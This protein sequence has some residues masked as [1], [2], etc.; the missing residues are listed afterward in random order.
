M[1]QSSFDASAGAEALFS[2]APAPMLVVAPDAPRFTILEANQAYC[3]V[4][5]RTRD[6]LVGRALFEAFPDNP[7]DPG[8]SGTANLQASMERAIATR[9][10]DAMPVQRYD[11]VGPDGQYEERCWEPVNAPVLEKGE[12]VAVIHHAFDATARLRAEA[13]VREA[14]DRRQFLLDI[15]DAT[16]VLTDPDAVIAATTRRLGERLGAARVAFADI[17][18]AADRAIIHGQWTSA[19]VPGLPETVRVSDFGVMIG[20]L[21]QRRT[22]RIDDICEHAATQDSIALLGAISA[23]AIVSV[24][25]HKEGRFLANLN[26]HHAAPRAWTDA[27][28]ALI[29]EVAER[30]WE[31]VERVRA[32]R[33]L[34][35]SEARY[36]QIVEGAEDFAIVQLDER[37]VVT[38]WNTGA[39]RILGYAREEAVGQPGA[40]FFTPEDRAAGAPD[41]EIERAAVEERAVNERWHVRKDG[42]RFW[43]SG[44]IMRSEGEQRGYLKV[45]RDRTAEHEAETQLRESETRFRNMADHAPVMMWVTDAA[46]FCTYLNKAWYDF[47]GQTVEQA[48]GF[49]WLNATHAEDKPEAERVF[50]ESNA[51]HAPFRA[52]YRLRRADGAYRWAIDAASPRFGPSGEYLG[53]VGS[54][55]DIDERRESERALQVNEERLRLA[56]EAAELG[57]WDVD[58]VEDLLIWPPRVKEMF[59][60]SEDRPVTMDD[61]YGGLHP[62]DRAATVEAFALACDPVARALYDVEYRT[63]G[64]E[65]QVVR[66]VSAKGRA[67]FDEAGRCLRVVGTAI[68]ITRRKVA[69]T[70]LRRSE[71]R[72]RLL[73]ELD[74]ALRT[75]RDAE[76]AMAY[77]A[78]LL[79]RHLGVARTAYAD[80]DADNDRFIIRDDYTAPG[81]ATSV[82]TYSLDLFGPRAS[83]DMRQ[84]RTL[85]VRNVGEEL[86]PGEGREMFQAIGIDAIIC[87]PLVKDGR[88]RAMMAVHNAA[89]RDWRADE[90]SLVETV[91]ER[92]WAHV[93][94]VAAE[95]RLRESEERYRTLFTSIESGFCVVEVAYEESGRTDY[96]VI[97]ANPAFFRQTGF[98]ETIVGQWLREAAPELEEAW[99]KTYGRIARTGA[100]ERFEQGS[101][102]LGRW[103][104]VYAFPIGEPEEQRLAI[105]FS[106]ISARRQ[107]EEDLRELNDTL[108]ARVEARTAELQAAHEQ[109]RQSQKMEAMGQLTGG[110]AHDF[111]NLL[112]PIVGSLDLLQRRGVGDERERRLI[113]GAVQS[114]DRAKTLVQ[115]LLSFARRQPLQTMAVDLTTLV[116]GMAE[117]IAS[118]TGPQIRVSVEAADN[119]PPAKAD[120]NQLEMALLNL[121]V[122]ARDAMPE[123]GTLRISVNEEAVAPGHSSKLPAGR[124]VRLSVADTGIGMNEETL[125]RSVEPFF[126]TKG[127]GKGTGLG[128]SSVHGL[129]SQ[130]GG[131]LT[132][133]S[134]QGVGTNV[135]LWLPI[136]HSSADETRIVPESS[137]LAATGTA[138]L[139]DDEELVRMSTADMLSELGYRVVEAAS[140]E[141]ALDKLREGL[142]PDLLVSDHLMPGMNG[143]DLARIV[144]AE[145]PGVQ[146]LIV[147]GYAEDDGVAPDLPRLTKPFR[148]DDLVARLANLQA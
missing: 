60:I 82:G 24:P 5:M 25:L 70:A 3:A 110:V 9:Q 64:K 28:V 67:L 31:W 43:G 72:L 142:H 128:L 113:G 143:T 141:E 36:R 81:I 23:R 98:S 105:L 91:V 103:F 19:G 119:L 87:C 131:A 80:V 77:A 22:L 34:R 102:A 140:A 133:Q 37:G 50:R 75:S 118:T 38:A 57:F 76:S 65:D 116:T 58:V 96:R 20:W 46:G 88:L 42:S 89:A 44:L 120:P 117:L 78:A 129:A 134:R 41:H 108:E 10:T 32:E 48:E 54:V 18:E 137:S 123:G 66:W 26:V 139:V 16:R 8:A 53:Y 84:G 51:A 49:G 47:T 2:A 30:T 79:G 85:V 63:V 62:E 7:D 90:I 138:L 45:F 69:E 136:S 35:D 21:R 144:Q 115:R 12:V 29:E 74:E 59:G 132:I 1:A 40:M 93:E 39:E 52:E 83:A 114:A 92:C 109:L 100:P 97:E 112:T 125:A 27:E 135:E 17:D 122:N 146:V 6:A 147:S 14:A 124:Y 111:N 127:I 56:T 99:F 68:D 121:A 95:A 145:R 106:D 107:A 130:L 86:A 73:T 4:T 94:R 148:K 104:D 55:I 15:A 11:I 61:F 101:E 126:S 33:N 13:A 71:A